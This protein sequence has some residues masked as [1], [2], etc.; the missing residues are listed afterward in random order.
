MIKPSSNLNYKYELTFGSTIDIYVL[1]SL[2]GTYKRLNVFRIILQLYQ[3]I[4]QYEK[5]CINSNIYVL[6]IALVT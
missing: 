5:H 4:N 6:K 1:F 2:L 3:H